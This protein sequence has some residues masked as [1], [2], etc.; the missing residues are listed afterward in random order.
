[1]VAGR[2]GHPGRGV[3]TGCGGINEDQP[4]AGHGGGFGRPVH[5]GRAGWQGLRLD[6]RGVG[7]RWSQR[8]RSVDISRALRPLQGQN[9]YAG[10]DLNS[11]L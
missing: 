10:A 8:G 5:P 3:H 11:Q 9:R 2:P 4:Q 1:M 6:S 7:T